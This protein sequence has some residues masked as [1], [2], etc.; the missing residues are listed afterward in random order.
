MLTWSPYYKWANNAL[1]VVKIS[2]NNTF[3]NQIYHS[4]YVLML[5]HHLNIS[6]SDYGNHVKY[7]FVSKIKPRVAA[8][9]G[10]FTRSARERVKTL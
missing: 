2:N 4:K 3:F 10:L 7:F 6:V 9:A 5:D 1:F 8:V